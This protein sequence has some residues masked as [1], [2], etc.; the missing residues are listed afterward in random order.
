MGSADFDFEVQ[1]KML[2][3]GL[4]PKAHFE[5]SDLES[6]I[7]NL[8]FNTPTD[9]KTTGRFTM[10]GIATDLKVD[11]RMLSFLDENE[12]LR[13][14]VNCSFELPL[15]DIFK[16]EGPDGPSPAKDRLQF[17]MKFYLEPK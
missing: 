5:F 10:M 11:G 8:R 7:S 4:F 1:N 3:M 16:V 6:S 12:N 2:K 13:L 14:E 9:F 15:F 17:F